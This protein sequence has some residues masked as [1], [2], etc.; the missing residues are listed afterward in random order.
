MQIP[1]GTE[2]ALK[3]LV[4]LVHRKA[5]MFEGSSGEKVVGE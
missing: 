5:Y 1:I 4:D 3:G 2:D